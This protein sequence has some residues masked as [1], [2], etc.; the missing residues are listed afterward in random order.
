MILPDNALGILS[1]L[2]TKE[3]ILEDDLILFCIGP[4]SDL[5]VCWFY[6]CLSR[7]ILDLHRSK[8]AQNWALS[9][10]TCVTQALGIVCELPLDTK[11]LLYLFPLESAPHPPL[12]HTAHRRSLG[13]E[14]ADLPSN[15]RPSFVP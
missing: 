7:V 3:I 9:A 5:A 2:H 12:H 4:D 10:K 13:L 8:G 15:P 1:V 14:C 11:G 6:Y